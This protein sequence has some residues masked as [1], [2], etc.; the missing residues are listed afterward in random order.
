MNLDFF[1]FLTFGCLPPFYKKTTITAEF[2]HIQQLLSSPWIVEWPIF[3][4]LVMYRDPTHNL[5]VIFCHGLI[6]HPLYIGQITKSYLI[7]SRVP[8][9]Q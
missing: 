3:Q 4:V 8:I 9:P 6:C 5:Y 7:K 2:S 1:D